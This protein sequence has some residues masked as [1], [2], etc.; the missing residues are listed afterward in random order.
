MPIFFDIADVDVFAIIPVITS[1]A[2]HNSFAAAGLVVMKPHVMSLEFYH[3]PFERSPSPLR[4]TG[5]ASA[6]RVGAAC[7]VLPVAVITAVV[8]L[9]VVLP[10]REPVLEGVALL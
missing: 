1:R 7:A 10:A 3:T 8:V 6:S 2:F 4:T 5:A 9:V